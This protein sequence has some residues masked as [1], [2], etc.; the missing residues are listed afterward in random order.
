MVHEWYLLQLA[1]E[2]IRDRI[3]SG[4]MRICD[5][6]RELRINCITFYWT[7]MRISRGASRTWWLQDLRIL[8]FDIL[9]LPKDSPQRNELIDILS[10]E[11]ELCEGRWED[12]VDYEKFFDEE[13][14]QEVRHYRGVKEACLRTKLEDCP[15]ERLTNVPKMAHKKRKFFKH[16][17]GHLKT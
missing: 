17:K 3:F 10:R 14:L 16:P 4:A 15:G 9:S 11:L 6:P 8:E 12:D 5:L 2:L 7:A 1:E 13:I